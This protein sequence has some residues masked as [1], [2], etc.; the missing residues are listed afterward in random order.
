[1][2]SAPGAMRSVGRIDAVFTT[3]S[4]VLETGTV[5][6]LP[7][8]PRNRPEASQRSRA[9]AYVT[10]VTCDSRGPELLVGPD[11]KDPDF[12]PTEIFFWALG[13]DPAF[14]WAARPVVSWAPNRLDIFGLGVNNESD[15][16]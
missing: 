1:M 4:Q 15:R 3:I 5:L 11:F 14:V 9:R 7:L 6:R 12:G 13:F 16:D 2:W 8:T 10:L